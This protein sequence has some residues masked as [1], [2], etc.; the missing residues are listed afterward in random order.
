MFLVPN[1]RDIPKHDEKFSSTVQDSGTQ[2]LPVESRLDVPTDNGIGMAVW[3]EEMHKGNVLKTPGEPVVTF[4]QKAQ[5]IAEKLA[6]DVTHGAVAL[7][8]LEEN[9]WKRCRR[10]QQKELLTL[11]HSVVFL[12]SGV[13]LVVSGS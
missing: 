5:G 11:R 8:K 9:L 2:A 7:S 12:A 10:L 6:Q 4:S 3:P 1:I 13:G